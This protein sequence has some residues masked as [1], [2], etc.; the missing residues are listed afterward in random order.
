MRKSI[1]ILLFLTFSCKSS[2]SLKEQF[3][4]IR[5]NCFICEP[6]KINLENNKVLVFEISKNE[7]KETIPLSDEKKDFILNLISEINLKDADSFYGNKRIR[8]LPEYQLTLG[9]KK[10]VVKDIQKSPPDIRKL[11][12]YINKTLQEYKASKSLETQK[13]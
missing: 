1:L 12:N 13:K 6:Y 3:S 9:T 4:L 5:S 10:I 2:T 11:I 7:V 8:D